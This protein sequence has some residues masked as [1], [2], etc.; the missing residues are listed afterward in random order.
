M[1][2]YVQNIARTSKAI[3]ILYQEMMYKI[4]FMC[5][6]KIK[7]IIFTRYLFLSTHKAPPLPLS[8]PHTRKTI[9]IAVC[10]GL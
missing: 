5:K 9:L 1:Y 10:R 8:P 6:V 3:K 4:D 2:G 7:S